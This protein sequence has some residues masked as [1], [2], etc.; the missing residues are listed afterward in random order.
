MSLTTALRPDI[1]EMNEEARLRQRVWKDLVAELSQKLD[2]G[3]EVEEIF[4]HIVRYASMNRHQIEALYPDVRAIL[5]N[6][7]LN[8][9]ISRKG[10]ALTVIKRRE[11][12]GN[13]ATIEWIRESAKSQISLVRR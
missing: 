2:E 9:A 8:Y 1:S 7:E 12:L 3:A 11:T 4:A 10:I 6:L 5:P 13:L